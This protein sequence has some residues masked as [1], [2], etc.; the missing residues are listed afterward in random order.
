MRRPEA[1]IPDSGRLRIVWL[2]VLCAA[3]GCA[4]QERT[5]SFRLRQQIPF[6]PIAVSV[7]GWEEVGGVHAPI[8]SLHT[9]EGEKAIA[10]F[11]VWSGLE[12]YAEPD[13]Q[14]FAESFLSGSLKLVDSGGFD[15]TAVAAMPR[16]HYNFTGQPA[17]ASR[18]WVV[19]FHAWVDSRGYTLRLSHP[20]PGEEAFDVAIVPLG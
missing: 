12:P 13:R 19:I 3:L 17:P 11:V 8:S 7:E 15:Y 9:P 4:T 18:D 6:G 20:D 5:A 1:P 2:V 14:V 10:V 16:E